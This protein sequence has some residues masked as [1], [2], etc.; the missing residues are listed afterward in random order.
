MIYEWSPIHLR[1]M[2]NQWYFKD[3]VNEV[4]TV[5]VW[6]DCCHYVYL[7]RLV[8]DTVF[9]NAIAQG[10]ECEDYFAFASGKEGERYLG[11][12]FGCHTGCILDESSLLIDRETAVAYRERL[13]KPIQQTTEAGSIPGAGGSA[14]TLPDGTSTAVTSASTLDQP[15]STEISASAVAKKQFYGTVSLNPVKAKL[16]FATIMDEVVQQFSEKYGVDVM[17]SVEIEARSKDG[18]DE[19]MQRTVKEN[20]NTLKFSNAEFEADE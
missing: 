8:N 15:G 11:F 20:C 3:G 1:N 12:S 2:L 5:K 9:R 14:T 18:F 7:P 17:I 13:Q 19:R 16:D 10:V 6:Q 4:N